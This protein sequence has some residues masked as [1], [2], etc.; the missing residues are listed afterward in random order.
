MFKSG[1]KFGFGFA[2]GYI[3]GI[4]VLDTTTKRIRKVINGKAANK[5]EP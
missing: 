2:I 5:E 1:F 3:V 4:A